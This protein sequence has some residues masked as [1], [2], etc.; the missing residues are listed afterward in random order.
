[1]KERIRLIRNKI[2]DAFLKEMHP[3]Q[4]EISCGKGPD[5]QVIRHLFFKINWWQT[6]QSLINRCYD[7]LP[8]FN[9][10][11]YHYYLPAFILHA[12]DELP[13]DSLVLEF[14]IYNLDCSNWSNKRKIERLSRFSLEQH[15][16]IIDFLELILSYVELHDYHEYCLRAITERKA[17]LP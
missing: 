3:S 16:V 2:E 13:N 7:K 14:L 10:I 11:G 8:F 1:M 15:S 9:S 17:Y 5:P 6:N 12:L 4:D